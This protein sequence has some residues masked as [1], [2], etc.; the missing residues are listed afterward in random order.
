MR[1]PRT[2]NNNTKEQIVHKKKLTKRGKSKAS[3]FLKIE[4][5]VSTELI[6][7]LFLSNIHL[8]LRDIF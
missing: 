2:M 3:K 1:I 8:Q 6:S 7:C 5:R 4:R